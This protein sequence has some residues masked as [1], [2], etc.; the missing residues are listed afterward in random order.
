MT[1]LMD[2]VFS[3]ITPPGRGAVATVACYGPD[4]VAIVDRCLRTAGRVALRDRP[5]ASLAYGR[6]R[7]NSGLGEDLIVVP[8][9]DDRLEIHCHGGNATVEVIAGVLIDHGMHQVPILDFELSRGVGRW[10]AEQTVC[11]GQAPTQRTAKFVLRQTG[12]LS[13]WLSDLQSLIGT[14][15][16]SLA[17]EKIDGVLAWESFS[18]HLIKPWSVVLCGRP[19]VGKS[20]LIN[21]IAGFERAIVDDTPGTTRDVVSQLTAVDGWPICLLDTAGIRSETLDK[22]ELAGISRSREM[23][24]QSDAVI[25]VFDASQPWDA[26]DQNLADDPGVDIVVFNKHDI[27]IPGERPDGLRVAAISGYGVPDL[28]NQLMSVLLPV[29]PTE[30]QPIPCHSSQWKRL[31]LCRNALAKRDAQQALLDLLG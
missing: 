11:L 20:S 6:W 7:V 26:I 31:R 27:E 24:E 9:S 19:N 23:I 5:A 29:E 21:R 4:V 17:T 30:E 15:E 25:G 22:V 1:D 10:E 2:N 12:L 3:Q 16:W 18:Q 14:H 8:H 13:R 28:L